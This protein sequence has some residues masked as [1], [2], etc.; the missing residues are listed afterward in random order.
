M[1][2]YLNFEDIE[3]KEMLSKLDLNFFLQQNIEEENYDQKDVNSLYSS[4]ETSLEKLKLKYK[5]NWKQANYFLE[6][7]VRKMFTGGFLTAL[8]HLDDGRSFSL[9][10]FQDVGHDLAYFKL[11][12]KYYKRKASAKKIWNIVTKVGSVLAI[13]L[14][15][16]KLLESLL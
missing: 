7:Q 5:G 15:I 13:V 16:I 4:Y 2:T 9:S 10:R 3:T 11:W 14:S 1:K 6:G 12:Q 8:F